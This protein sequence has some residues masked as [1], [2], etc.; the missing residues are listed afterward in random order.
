[1]KFLKVYGLLSCKIY[2]IYKSIF[3]K[4]LNIDSKIRFAT[5]FDMNG[6]VLFSIHREGVQNLLSTEESQKSLQFAINAWKSRNE[7]SDKI[8]AGKYALV[9]YEK[10]KRITLPL[11]SEHILYITTDV[12]A[13]HAP[14]I[15]RALRLKHDLLHSPEGMP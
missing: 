12:D 3:D 4:V 10:L 13:D 7:V 14:I 9:E 11:D 5:I 1:M 2:V 8:G 6:K 15:T